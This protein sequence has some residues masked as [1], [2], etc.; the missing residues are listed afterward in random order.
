MAYK[1]V[2]ETLYR[3]FFLQFKKWLEMKETAK[4]N[5]E[6][7]DVQTS[8]M[9]ADFQNAQSSLERQKA[10]DEVIETIKYHLQPE[11]D[12]FRKEGRSRSP[13]FLLW[14]D[15]IVRVMQPLKLYLSSSRMGNWEV[16]EFAKT[17]LLPLLFATNRSTYAKYMSYLILQ[18]KQLPPDIV[19]GF[20][21][22]L[23]VA[24]L[25]QGQVNKVWIDYV[26][27]ATENKALKGSGGIIG[28]T[29]RDNALARWFLARPVTAKFSM[30]FRENVC[31]STRQALN[32]D[33]GPI[34]HSAKKN[35][36]ERFNRNI[37][38]MENM[39]EGTFVDPFDLTEPP[40]NLVNIATGAVA[41]E[42]VEQSMLH[43]LDKGLTKAKTFVEE[44][45][46]IPEGEMQT[47]KSFYDPLPRS[48]LHTFSE[49]NKSV[50]V[51]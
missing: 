46:V 16:H 24:K 9:A 37:A 32:S 27:E 44:R 26:L 11:L 35:E 36:T 20:K 51:K 28:L 10:I 21:D 13:T 41:S 23:F 6:A 50:K 45:F 38:R 49:L 33:S 31:K 19:Q 47:K 39:F 18:A 14:D 30:Q 42:E 48:N 3:R 25:S 29:L 7:I 22:G 34:H 17:C 2:E 43:C 40:A 8:N 12:E 1:L 15:F 4:I 5:F